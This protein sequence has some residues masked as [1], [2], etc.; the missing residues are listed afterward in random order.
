MKIGIDCRE[1]LHPE[2]GESAGVG[3]YVHHLVAALAAEDVRNEYVLFFDNHDV[4]EAKRETIGGNPRFVSRIL[5][6]RALR[7]V[8]FLYSHA[9][10]AAAFKRERLDVL[11]GPANVV[12]LFYRRPWVVTVHDLAIY[13]HPEWF[14][15]GMSGS[16][17]FSTTV[18]VPHSLK[19]A[20]RVIAVSHA[21]ARD[22]RRLFDIE[23]RRIDVIP[24]GMNPMPASADG[25]AI[26]KRYA[27]TKGKYF[28]FLGTIEPRK[29]IATAI[30]AFVEA[31]RRGWLPTNASFVIAGGRGWKNEDVF[32]AM[33]EANAVLGT[34]RVRC[35]GYLPDDHKHAVL[36]CAAA[37]VFPSHYEGFGLPV[38]EAMGLGTPVI[39]SDT[40]ALTELC[41]GAAVQR[42]AADVD[43]FAEAMRTV[44][45]DAAAVEKFR[46]RGLERAKTF[47]WK[48]AA[49]ETIRTYERAFS[50]RPSVM[51][52]D[53]T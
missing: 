15:A 25:A 34:E 22:A 37:L 36:F 16:P 27:L 1:I 39:A 18:L 26:L 23:E 11:H 32:R 47:T 33:C 51:S 20:E 9:F 50:T 38:L 48:K 53:A 21:T 2:A 29:N 28:L 42:N 30:H 40:D 43:G 6:F 24:E 12:P 7:N 46:A 31:V 4:A 5:P 49:Q 41:G 8:P 10:V 13:E 44:W 35:I 45:H 17:L 19:H 14:P 52:H 3:H